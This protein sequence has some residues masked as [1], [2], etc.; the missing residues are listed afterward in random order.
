MK[1][2]YG[3]EVSVGDSVRVLEIYKGFLDM[4][5]EEERILHEAMLDQVYIV[6]E[7]VENSTKASVSFWEKAS[8]GLYHGGLYML[9]HEF[10]LVKKLRGS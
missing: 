1:D 4:L 5:P 8:E 9:S 10:E 7:I 6:E 3:K 2:K